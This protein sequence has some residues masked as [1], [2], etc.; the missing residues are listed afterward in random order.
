MADDELE[1]ILDDSLEHYCAV[2]PLA[3]LE[4]RIV[5]RLAAERAVRSK[6]TSQ[7]A[8][9][10]A[11]ATGLAAI[12]VFTFVHHQA[13]PVQA[14]L[15]SV[16]SPPPLPLM[17]PHQEFSLFIPVRRAKPNPVNQR[18]PKQS[19]FPASVPL[20][21]EERALVRFAMHAPQGRLDELSKWQNQPLTPIS[22][23]PVQVEPVTIDELPK[24]GEGVNDDVE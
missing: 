19:L 4:Q 15:T 5:Q 7:W 20:T 1:K 10:F 18:L 3:G 22:I 6:R 16:F 14:N 17:R 8:L 24:P 13:T 9:A 21:R 2:E 12:A 23:E 11:C